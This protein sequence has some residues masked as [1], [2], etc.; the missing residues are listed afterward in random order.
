[1]K[2][3]LKKKKDLEQVL[4]CV[5][6]KNFKCSCGCNVFTVIKHF[7]FKTV[8]QCNCCKKQYVEDTK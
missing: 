4:L 2:N 3:I 8:Y 6:G 7:Y 5:G 1:M